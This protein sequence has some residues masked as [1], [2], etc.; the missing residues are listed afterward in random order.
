M[1]ERKLVDELVSSCVAS[2]SLDDPLNIEINAIETD[3]LN[4]ENKGEYLVAID[5]KRSG[6]DGVEHFVLSH[7]KYKKLIEET[8]KDT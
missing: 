4:F 8:K 7:S 2:A 6:R 1:S 3:R 5:V